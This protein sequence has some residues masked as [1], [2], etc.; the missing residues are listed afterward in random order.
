MFINSNIKNIEKIL[1][2]CYYVFKKRNLHKIKKDT[3]DCKESNAIP[4]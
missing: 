4:I 3:F 1:I 2:I